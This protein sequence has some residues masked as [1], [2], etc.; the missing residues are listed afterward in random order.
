MLAPTEFQL[1]LDQAPVMLW[2]AGADLRC[3]F[4]SAA[5]LRFT[6]QSYDDAVLGGW[7]AGVHPDDR[8]RC[9]QAFEQG[10]A[11]RTGFSLEYR[12]RRH[13]GAWRWVADHVVLPDE[14][15]SNASMMG[16][17]LDIQTCRDDLDH[18]TARLAELAHELRSPLQGMTMWVDLLRRASGDANPKSFATAQRL[19]GRIGGLVGDLADLSRIERGR[20]LELRVEPFDLAELLDDVVGICRGVLEVR[21]RG[22]AAALS[23]QVDLD[24]APFPVRGDRRRLEQV[25]QNLIE[26]AIKFSPSGGEIQVRVGREGGS[27]VLE[28]TDHGIGIPAADLPH[29]RER[30]FRA[31]NATTADI[32]GTGLGLSIIEEIVTAHGGRLDIVSQVDVGTSVI[33]SLPADGGA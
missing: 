30:F 27:Y 26:N 25:V 32:P 5:W 6:G 3:D 15:E 24:Q 17:A 31:G 12:R 22:P 10:R 14:R 33:I 11:C 4:V 23:L 2:R 21:D 8:E 1:L 16:A 28:V 9:R 19:I 29:L 18:R 20:R 7:L 13:D